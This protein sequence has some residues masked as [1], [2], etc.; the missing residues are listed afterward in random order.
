MKRGS[1]GGVAVSHMGAIEAGVTAAVENNVDE[2]LARLASAS[3][4]DD[5]I[6][7]VWPEIS[8]SDEMEKALYD[9]F[10]QQFDELLRRFTKQ[11]VIS[12]RRDWGKLLMIE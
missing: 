12:C 1:G 2:V 9:L 3:G 4:V 8:N 11:W 7:N 6:E 10:Y 5:F